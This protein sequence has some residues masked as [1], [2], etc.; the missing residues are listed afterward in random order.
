MGYKKVTFHATD[1]NGDEIYHTNV[2]MAMGETYAIVCLESINDEKERENLVKVLKD[3]GK[4][5]MAITLKQVNH[6]AGNMLKVADIY[7]ESHLIMSESAAGSLTKAQIKEIAALNKP[8]IIPINTIEKY[9]G[10][11]IRCMMA[12]IFLERK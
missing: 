10:G 5:V 9:G 8:I 1:E 2:M 6:F 11:S 12:E 7:G 4:E 3:T